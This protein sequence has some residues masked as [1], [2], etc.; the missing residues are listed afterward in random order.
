MKTVYLLRTR[1]SDQGT[2]GMLI[3]DGFMCK[4]LDIMYTIR[5]I[6]CSHSSIS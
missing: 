5:R 2:E 1:T 6:Q 4:T 3:T